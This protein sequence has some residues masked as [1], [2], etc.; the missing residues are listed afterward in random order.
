MDPRPQKQIPNHQERIARVSIH[1]W[2]WPIADDDDDRVVV[3]DFHRDY[4][5]SR[6]VAGTEDD[7][8]IDV[9]VDIYFDAEEIAVDSRWH[10]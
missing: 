8:D 5:A 10:N 3:A 2:E 9:A 4:D 7:A 1:E 6:P